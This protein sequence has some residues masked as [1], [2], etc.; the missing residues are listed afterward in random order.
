MNSSTEP[1]VT[2]TGGTDRPIVQLKGDF[3]VVLLV[4]AP[5]SG[6]TWLQRLLG[7]YPEIVTTQE[8]DLL[9][10][11]ILPWIDRWH[12]QLLEDPKAWQARRHRG[13]SAVLTTDE[14]TSLLRTAVDTVYGK[15]AQLKPG[16]EVVLD[17]NPAYAL[18]TR[19]IAEVLP[20]ARFIHIVRDG[21]DV[22]ASLVRAGR[23]WGTHWAPRE[24]ESAAQSWRDHVEAARSAG[25]QASRYLEVR[26]EELSTHSTEVFTK[27]LDFCGIAGDADASRV[28]ID[29]FDLAYSK[30]APDPSAWQDSLVWSGEVMARLGRPPNEP[31][32]FFGEG[33]NGWWRT[34]W[35]SYDRWQFD[36]AAGQLLI[37][38]GYEPDAT[39]AHGPVAPSWYEARRTIHE[40]A[41][42][43]SEVRSRWRRRHI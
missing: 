41:R 21:R 42:L 37:E 24:L 38:L 29:K 9:N 31:A 12:R 36:R 10:G 20:E 30:D 34:T 17:K 16:A 18:N 32:G 7:A 1:S 33:R 27:C 39:W 13:L 43:A 22:A 5:R 26:Y 14:F 3:Q 15:A 6:T 4:G 8:S 11:Y 2:T 19:A 28:I 25:L 40:G 35:S 23:T